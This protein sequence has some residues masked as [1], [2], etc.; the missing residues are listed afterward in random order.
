M[1]NLSIFLNKDKLNKTINKFTFDLIKP[2]DSLTFG[3]TSIFSIFF[4]FILIFSNNIFL[5]IN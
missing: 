3:F 2:Y 4:D 1:W 5:K